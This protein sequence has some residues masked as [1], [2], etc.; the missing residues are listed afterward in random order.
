VATAAGLSAGL[1]VPVKGVETLRVIASATF[2]R[3]P[4]FSCIRARG[5]EV[6]AA[7]YS[8]GG[9][10][11]DVLLEPGVYRAEGLAGKL[12]ADFRDVLASGSGR[13]ELPDAPVRWLPPVLDNPR[14]SVV[15][16]LAREASARDGFDE[17]VE[18]L[19]L[20]EWNQEAAEVDP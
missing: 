13:S 3:E 4:V 6:Y 1:G 2:P 19:Y 18:P 20:R 12:Q 17:D 11:S 14:P 15:A 10:L 5:G 16:I 8:G 7:L 9:A